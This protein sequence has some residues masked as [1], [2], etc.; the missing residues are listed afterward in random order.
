MHK[1]EEVALDYSSIFVLQLI[2]IYLFL[3]YSP[4]TVQKFQ[5]L[6]EYYVW[7]P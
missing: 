4:L 6:D 3:K 2:S 5:D 1:S 7:Y